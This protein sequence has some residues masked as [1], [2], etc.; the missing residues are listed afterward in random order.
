M[1]YFIMI[2]PI[3]NIATILNETPRN[4]GLW[5]MTPNDKSKECNKNGRAGYYEKIQ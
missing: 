3:N 4:R 5:Y 1:H 2:L